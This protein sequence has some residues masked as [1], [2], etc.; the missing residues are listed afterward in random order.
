MS[1]PE[2]TFSR[3]LRSC[4]VPSVSFWPPSKF[5]RCPDPERDW[6]TSG[7]ARQREALARTEDDLRQHGVRC[8]TLIG[9]GDAGDVLVRLAQ[10][11][12]ADIL[13]VGSKGM[14]RRVLGS[15]PNTVTHKAACSVLVVNTA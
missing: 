12:S 6:A 2:L 4:S 15:V 8:R 11:C 10:D 5:G 13:V 3:R 9:E 1:L 14:E 7:S